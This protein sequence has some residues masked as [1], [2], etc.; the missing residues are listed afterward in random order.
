MDLENEWTYND[1]P[2]RSF[3]GDCTARFIT[4]KSLNSLREQLDHTKV[5]QAL[6]RVK[7]IIQTSASEGSF[8]CMISNDVL[9]D[10]FTTEEECFDDALIQYVVHFLRRFGYKV[11]Y[12][13]LIYSDI[14]NIIEISW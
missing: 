1:E 14:S 7:D 10:L 8:S 2:E 4:D 11:K 9:E 5:E 3:I 12:D 13:E 6:K